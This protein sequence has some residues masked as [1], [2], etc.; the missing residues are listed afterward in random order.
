M[1]AQLPEKRFTIV[2]SEHEAKYRQLSIRLQCCW[3]RNVRAVPS[4][5]GKE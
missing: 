4:R 2:L 3:Y 5:L 1:M